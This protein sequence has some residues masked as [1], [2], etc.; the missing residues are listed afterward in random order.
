MKFLKQQTLSKFSASDNVLF[1]NQYGRAVMDLTGGLR[2][3]Q[4]TT[5]Q[6]PQVTG[7]RIPGGPSGANGFI[8]YNTSLDPV[9]GNQIG[10]EAYINGTWEVIRAP[11]AATITKQTL[12]PGDYVETIFGPLSF[13]PSSPDNILVLI[14]NVFQI[15]GTNFNILYNHLGSGNAYIEFNDAVPLN[16][17]VTIYFGFAN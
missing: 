3:P 10:I 1:T 4:G 12:G 6:R 9:T 14:E 11:G 15:S 13:I 8:R 16:K 17:D 5:A 7:V 2:I